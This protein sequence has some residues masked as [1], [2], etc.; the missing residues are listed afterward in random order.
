MP[1][2]LKLSDVS[3]VLRRS[4]CASARPPPSSDNDDPL[5][6]IIYCRWL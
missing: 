6:G 5:Y 1:R 4:A 2:A 3:V